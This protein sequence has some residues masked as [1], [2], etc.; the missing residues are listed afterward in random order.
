MSSRFFCKATALAVFPR[1]FFACMSAPAASSAVHTAMWPLCAAA[2]KGRNCVRGQPASG[3]APAPSNT[4]TIS[5]YPPAAALYST[6]KPSAPTDSRSAPASMAAI[7]PARSQFN[8]AARSSAQRANLSSPSMLEPAECS[9]TLVAGGSCANVSSG[10]RCCC[11]PKPVVIIPFEGSTSVYL[12]L[13][14]DGLACGFRA[15][16]AQDLDPAGLR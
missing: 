7:T 2:C 14:V 5:A 3:L 12:V 15:R 10:F 1:L 4:S 13:P 16:V 8:P 9:S 11:W 6:V